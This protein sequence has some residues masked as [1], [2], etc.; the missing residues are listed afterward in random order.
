MPIILNVVLG[1]PQMLSNIQMILICVAVRAVHSLNVYG[2]PALAH[3]P[4]SLR[5]PMSFPHLACA[6]SRLR[7]DCSPAHHVTYART[8]SL[9]SACCY[10][11][12]ASSASSSRSVPCP[13]SSS[14]CRR[15]SLLFWLTIVVF[16]TQVILVSP[17]Q[18][19]ALLI[20]RGQVRQ[21]SRRPDTGSTL[22][23]PER[24]L[25]HARRHAV[26]VR[27]MRVT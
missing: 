19:R 25:L 4:Q 27:I 7:A 1:V 5:R 16:F 17:G 10:T 21:L 23:S 13:C 6:S 15:H 9:T 14:F 24:V 22:R 8:A 2:L 26:G 12:M 3:T 11:R 18:R 20:A